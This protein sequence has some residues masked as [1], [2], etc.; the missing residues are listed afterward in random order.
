MSSLHQEV[1]TRANVTAR[2]RVEVTN[3]VDVSVILPT[4]NRDEPLQ[5]TL[6]FILNQTP[7]PR[8]IIVID[9]STSHDAATKQ[10]IDDLIESSRII[11]VHQ[12]EPNAQRAR[13]QGIARAHGAILL[14]LD[15]DIIPDADLVGAHWKNYEDPSIGA[16]CGFFLDPGE[17]PVDT[18][19]EICSRPVT[20]WIYSPHCYTKRAENYLW[21]SGNGSIRREIAVL[22]GGFDENYTRTLFDDTDFCCRLR[23][24]GVRIVHDPEARMFHSKER[25]GG[26]RPGEINEYVIADSSKWYTWS[27]FFWVNFG[28]SAWR[29][30]L[31]RL[32]GCVFRRKNLARP[33]FLAI[34]LGHF[35]LGSF[36]AL[37]AIG[38]GR[39]LASFDEVRQ[40]ATPVLRAAPSRS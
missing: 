28:F 7:V 22:A 2:E 23:K 9:Q 12:P 14:F 11:Y 25:S 18:L 8:E 4:Y 1:L 31:A 21:P 35:T 15:D 37:V 10:F 16:V 27:Y 33:W 36:R 34:A 38:R 30:I 17:E 20:G 5:K 3:V 13:N 29:E 26:K 40:L 32:R 24:L 39:R 6:T 19:P